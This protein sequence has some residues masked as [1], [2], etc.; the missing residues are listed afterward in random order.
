MAGQVIDGFSLSLT[1]TVKLQ[2][3]EL[4]AASVAVQATGVVPLGKAKPLAG[5]QIT[6]TLESQLSA[7]VGA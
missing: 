6:V 4:F 5:E 2:A 3:E 1:V 7:A